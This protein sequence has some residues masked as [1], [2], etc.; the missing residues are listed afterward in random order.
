MK[1]DSSDSDSATQHLTPRYTK[2]HL[3]IILAELL[4][5][6]SQKSCDTRKPQRP[7]GRA[8]CLVAQRYIPHSKATKV[9]VE[10][11]RIPVAELDHSVQKKHKTRVLDRS[12]NFSTRSELT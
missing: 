6:I 3:A 4:Q 12:N 11:P 2:Y 7:L 5:I 10:K 8:V 1:Q 9:E